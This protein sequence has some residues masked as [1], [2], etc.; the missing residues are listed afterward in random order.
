MTHG[1]CCRRGGREAGR[2]IRIREKRKDM[3]RFQVPAR[4]PRRCPNASADGRLDEWA[5]ERRTSKKE[6]ERERKASDECRKLQL[7][8]YAV[9][10]ARGNAKRTPSMRTI[11]LGGRIERCRRRRR[12]MT[13]RS[14][15]VAGSTIILLM[16]FI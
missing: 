14:R 2:K 3:I 16:C 13:P 9:R 8:A 12:D 15:C 4:S 11:F 10:T 7:L 5:L 6:R 1:C